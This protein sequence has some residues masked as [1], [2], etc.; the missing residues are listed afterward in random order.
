M[1]SSLKNLLLPLLATLLLL[2]LLLLSPNVNGD[3][4]LI[5]STCNQ[6]AS[7]NLCH[8]CLEPDH[9]SPV[10]DF[11]ILIKI[12]MGCGCN[13]AIMMANYVKKLSQV[14]S[15]V[16]M[17][18]VLNG[19]GA[20]FSQASTNLILSDMAMFSKNY[21]GAMDEVSNAENWILGCLDQY[22]QF[23]K[24]R[25]Q[26]HLLNGIIEFEGLV[27]IVKKLINSFV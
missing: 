4:A 16:H 20:M 25:F 10:A 12:V 3:A 7:P 9:R 17:R 5:Q 24:L 18:D 11:E 2:L 1:N 19:C 21:T 6:T 8:S 15:D 26:Q 13:Q 27:Q 14:A 23:P 22:R